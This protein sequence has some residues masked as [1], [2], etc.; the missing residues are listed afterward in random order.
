MDRIAIE[1]YFP[2]S[3]IND[4][5]ADDDSFLSL[6][7]T[8]TPEYGSHSGLELLDGERFHKVIVGTEV[9]S[10]HDVPVLTTGGRHDDG[11]IGDGPDH[12][13]QLHPVEIRESEIEDDKV[14]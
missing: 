5:R 13:Q 2:G 8:R 11:D 1:R 4:K 7:P 9:E 14:G 12:L 3:D 10:A 6:P